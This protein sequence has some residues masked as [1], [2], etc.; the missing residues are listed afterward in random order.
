MQVAGQR[1]W[2]GITQPG[3]GHLLRHSMATDV[4]C[5]GLTSGMPED[6]GLPGTH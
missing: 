6:F 5:S 3:T 2:A 4:H 1:K